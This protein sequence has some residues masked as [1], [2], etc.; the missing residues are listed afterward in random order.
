MPA[1]AS[2]WKRVGELASIDPQFQPYVAARDAI[3]SQL[4]DLAYFLRSYSAEFDASPA[5]LQEV[6]DRLAV[7]ERLKKKHG[8]ALA[9]RDRHRGVARARAGSLEQSRR[10]RRGAR[11]R[12]RARRAPRTSRRAEALSAKRRVAAAEF[13]ERLEASLA[14][15]AMAR[16]RCEVRFAPSR[17]REGVDGARPGRGGVLH[18]AEPGRGSAAARAD[19]VGRRAVAADAGAEDAGLDRRSGQDA[20]LR[21]SRR[22]HRRRGR[23]HR[24][25]PAQ[26]AGGECQ[27]LCITHLPQIAAYGGTHYRIE[28]SL[29]DGRTA[30]SVTRLGGPRARSRARAHDR[31]RG[32]LSIRQGQRPRNAEAPL[33]VQRIGDS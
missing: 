15:L 20:H 3:K 4:E 11:R 18:L 2:V 7:L 12:H 19:R 9:G 27:V 31:R 8:P 13:S 1:L 16:T 22:R 33:G 30:T 23:R 25:G 29:K 26:G 28:K 6:E 21:R 24:R 10:A 32:G 5:R 17:G 14:D